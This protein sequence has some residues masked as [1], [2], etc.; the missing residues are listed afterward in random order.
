MIQ[1]GQLG[2]DFVYMKGFVTSFLN[3]PTFPKPGCYECQYK[4]LVRV[5][6][7]PQTAPLGL[8]LYVGCPPPF[9]LVYDKRLSQS[10]S[11]NNLLNST[12][13]FI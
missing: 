5:L 6:L 8:G 11:P 2:I 9:S 1:I 7:F 12:M 13:I 10:N 4:A 3:V